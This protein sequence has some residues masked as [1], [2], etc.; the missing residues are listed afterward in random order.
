MSESRVV[1]IVIGPE[2]RGPVVL[3]EE[4]RAVAGAGLEG[5]RYFLRHAGGDHDPENEI[6]V[7]AIEG[8]E[9]AGEEAG[10]ELTPLDLRRNVVTRGVDLDLPPGTL[11]RIGEA[12]IEVLA[13]NP[14][15]RYLQEMAGKPLLKPMVG[16]GGIRGRIVRSGTIRVGD[17]VAVGR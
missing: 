15:C 9:A 6:T 10:I 5:D 8:I 17:P 3:V 1:D 12:A 11:L 2:E 7:V 14:P 4:A 16:R 13:S